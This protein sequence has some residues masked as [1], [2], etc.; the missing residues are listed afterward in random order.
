[1][2]DIGA[3]DIRQNNWIGSDMPSPQDNYDYYRALR[4]GSIQ[5]N[6]SKYN[7]WKKYFYPNSIDYVFSEHMLEH[8]NDKEL[9]HV[10]QNVYLFL[11]P[12]GNFRVAVPD[13]YRN[14]KVYLEEISPPAA[15]HKQLFNIDSL[16]ALLTKFGFS[17]SPLEYFRDSKLFLDRYSEKKGKVRRSFNNDTQ[18]KFK[19]NNHFYTSLIVDAQKCNS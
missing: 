13:G 6:A 5:L 2:L 14:Q 9:T 3:K 7:D 17:V 18:T 19:L 12:N 10:L 16:T 8:L 15:G 1:M 4:S 11:K